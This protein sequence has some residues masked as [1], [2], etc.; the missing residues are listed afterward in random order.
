MVWH[1]SLIDFV[2]GSDNSEPRQSW[3]LA[4]EVSVAIWTLSYLYVCWSRSETILNA[5]WSNPK[6]VKN[7]F[8]FSPVLILSPVVSQTIVLG[9]PNIVDPNTIFLN[10]FSLNTVT[11]ILQGVASAVL[12]F[13]D[14]LLLL[15]FTKF[16]SNLQTDM[17]SAVTPRFLIISR[18]GIAASS[19]CFLY[20]S[21]AIVKPLMTVFN[22][23]LIV[24]FK[25]A[26]SVLM[27]LVTVILLLMKVA[28]LK[29]S[30][31]KKQSSKM[32]NS[33]N[34]N[35]TGGQWTKGTIEIKTGSKASS[36]L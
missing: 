16:I 27:Q 21:I 15:S 4:S 30:M 11:Y 9:N 5:I 10:Q 36:S 20:S 23:S 12:L 14:S 31:V 29:E 1:F 33:E 28:L 25:V 18:Y 32:A 3:Y 6:L 13:L 26:L 2:T 34:S 7:A 19:L 8:F 22:S 24:Y 35:N 17:K